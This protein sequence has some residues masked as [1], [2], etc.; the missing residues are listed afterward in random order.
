MYDCYG[1][2]NMI[3]GSH[4]VTPVAPEADDPPPPQFAPEANDPY[5]SVAPEADDHPL[6]CCP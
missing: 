2:Q 3:Y 4:S 1:I 5:P 6:S